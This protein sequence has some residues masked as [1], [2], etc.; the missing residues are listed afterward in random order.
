MTNE[1]S[2]NGTTD[3]ERDTS[4]DG[5]PVVDLHDRDE[6]ILR[7]L[8][9][10]QAALL[11]HPVAGQAVFNAL[12]SEGRNFA[13]TCDGKAA[14][15]KLERSELLHRARLIFDFGTLSMLEHDPP[16]IMP[17][18]Y[19]D[20]LFML[21]SGDRADHILHRLFDDGSSDE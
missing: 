17:S 3:R 16:D 5:I 21:A 20:T 13:K 14:R 7:V 11:K 15:D 4:S 12:V 10:L 6:D 1:L 9:A 19:I 8:R 18:A 2:Q